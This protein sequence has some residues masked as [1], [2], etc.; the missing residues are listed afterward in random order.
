MVLDRSRWYY[1]GPG[2]RGERVAV[3]RCAWHEPMP[4]SLVDRPLGTGDVL[5]MLFHDPVVIDRVPAAAMSLR[6]WPRGAGHHYGSTDGEWRHSWV[7][8]S[9]ELAERLA[10]RM[11]LVLGPEDP[12]PIAR[13][14]RQLV[15]S[16]AVDRDP[17]LAELALRAVLRCVEG[18]HEQRD[19]IPAAWLELRRWLEAHAHEEHALPALAARVGLAKSQF[20][21]RFKRYFGAAPLA[22]IQELRLERARWLL[23]DRNRPIAQ[24]AREVGYGD[25]GYFGRLIKRRYGRPPSGLRGG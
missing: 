17:A 3:D 18:L 25:L 4:P 11:P 21:Q 16:A 14:L 15:R 2:L 1:P 13:H 24:V 22:Y 12:E 8:C 19:P 10:Q 7:H 20:S 5:L 9:G 6:C 23:R